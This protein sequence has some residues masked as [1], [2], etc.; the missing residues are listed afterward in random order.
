MWWVN[1]K[2]RLNR[3]V[4]RNYFSMTSEA[5]KHT[6]LLCI[7]FFIKLRAS[8]P[9]GCIL[10]R[11]YYYNYNNTVLKFEKCQKVFQI[12]EKYFSVFGYTEKKMLIFTW[13]T[14][15][16]DRVT[17][18]GFYGNE[19]YM[20]IIFYEN[21][22]ICSRNFSALSFITRPDKQCWGKFLGNNFFFFFNFTLFCECIQN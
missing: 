18:F 6:W 20:V 12:L 22:I 1:V 13:S 3:C 5:A 10:W 2:E 7:F 16:S 9:L 21:L 8:L 4:L 17:F 11:T 15:F 14:I 19:K